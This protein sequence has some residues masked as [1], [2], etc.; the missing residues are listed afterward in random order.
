MAQ[1]RLD[2]AIAAFEAAVQA[3]PSE[4]DYH[5]DLGVMLLKTNRPAEARTH[6]EAALRLD[7]GHAETRQLLQSLQ[8]GGS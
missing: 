7:A 2:E 1:G 4:P 8:G 3:G 5:Y 6:F